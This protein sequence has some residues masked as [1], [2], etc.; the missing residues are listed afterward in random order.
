MI[1]LAIK[2]FNPLSHSIKNIFINA[3]KPMTGLMK[4]GAIKKT[5]LRQPRKRKFY[6]TS[7]DFDIAHSYAKGLPLVKLQS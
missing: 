1:A 2:L 3:L 4:R 5:S 6:F 7:S